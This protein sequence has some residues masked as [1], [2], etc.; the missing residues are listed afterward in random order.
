VPP[1]PLLPSLRDS[2]LTAPN[3]TFGNPLWEEGCPRVLVLRLSPF[4]DVERSSPHIFLASRVRR[5]AP[6]AY[7]D[8]AFLPTRQDR[9]ALKAAGAPLI[10][11]LQSRRPLADFDLI[12]VS[13]S[14][15]PELVNL[16]ALLA[17]SGVPLWASRRGPEWPAIILGGSSSAA[18]HPIVRPD[19]DCMADALFFGEGEGAVERIAALWKDAAGQGKRAL[20]ELAAGQGEG[21]WPAGSLDR[22]VRRAAAPPN[23][24][25]ILPAPVL[26]GAEAGT[27]RI[28]VT[29]GCPCSC[30]F[31]FEAFDRRPFRQH[32]VP[33]LLAAVRRLKEETGAETLELESFN[34][35][36]HEGI[37][38]LLRELGRIFLRVSPMSQRVDILAREPGLL[39]QELAAGKRSFTLGIEGVSEAQRRFLHK[40][41]GE[42]EVR[43]VLTALHAAPVRELKLFFILTGRETPGDMEELAG[44]AR[45]LKETR[46]REAT[47]AH[48]G[49]G[50]RLIFS[51]GLLVRMPF[52]PLRHDPCLLQ[53]KAWRPLIGKAK[54]ICETNGF[55]F[56]LA[57]SW[58][59]YLAIQVLAAGGHET[60]ALLEELAREGCLY[61]EQFPPRAR[62][63]IEGWLAA[64]EAEAERNYG[65]KP[66]GFP[67][68]FSFLE[69][70]GERSEL[71]GRY[72]EA[73]AGRDD[74][75]CRRGAPRGTCADCPGCTRAP[76][77]ADAPDAAARAS[78]RRGAG[79][80]LAAEIAELTARKARLSPVYLDVVIP[81]AAAAR[82]PEWRNAWLLRRL[83]GIDPRQGE[84]VLSV[85]ECV[86][87]PW[88]AA[89]ASPGAA[90]FPAWFGQSVAAVSAWEGGN[91]SGLTGEEGLGPLRPGFVP[92]SWETMGIRI[93]IPVEET[94]GLSGLV[95]HALEAQHTPVTLRREGDGFRIEV[96]EKAR[97][98]HGI[99]GG[100]FRP[101]GALQLFELTV[102]SGFSPAAFMEAVSPGAWTHASMEVTGLE[103]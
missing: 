25:E 8:M 1:I 41:L 72:A 86:V 35:N 45:W 14:C 54:S 4:R 52:T 57:T 53:E 2:A 88:A 5:G 28:A 70:P 39:E 12:L 85:R 62:E 76:P 33:E 11:G 38:E 94:Q 26:P 73:R 48:R 97:K 9:D 82:S 51:F 59:D 31:C 13:H 102:G 69:A 27:A 92:G 65:E 21:L 15:I 44:L 96:G 90:G 23:A 91:L 79:L 89:H 74:G 37:G 46:A 10:L 29:R 36:T 3:P 66:E 18:A 95:A 40:S 68:P 64:H 24:V 60:A 22:A 34:F 81:A 67:F 100:G 6:G 16:P 71:Y 87:T 83:M 55:E 49:G 75:Y 47:G 101:E 20:I 103:A 42:T 61:D 56:R 99:Q 30:S 50:P 77:A 19:G 17:G 93:L 43:R 7:V 78:A 32:P 84:N 98:R 80:R 58:T 63:I